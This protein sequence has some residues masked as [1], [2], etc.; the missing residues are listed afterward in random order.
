MWPPASVILAIFGLVSTRTFSEVPKPSETNAKG[1]EAS[2]SSNLDRR[3]NQNLFTDSEWSNR[4]SDT[5]PFSDWNE[6]NADSL[7]AGTEFNLPDS[8]D[9]AY[10]MEGSATTSGCNAPT[11]SKPRLKRYNEQCPKETEEEKPIC[12]TALFSIP[13]CCLG[14][15]FAEFII[16]NRCAPCRCF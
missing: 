5:A 15:S 4:E 12:G 1:H 9:W 14:P 6:A 11:N 10:Q 2:F 16:V 8:D 13:A 3:E 7:F